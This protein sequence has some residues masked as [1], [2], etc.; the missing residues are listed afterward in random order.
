MSFFLKLLTHSYAVVFVDAC[1]PLRIV[2]GAQLVTELRVELVPYPP[3][4][5]VINR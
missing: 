3:R 2:S 4:F 5:A 1:D